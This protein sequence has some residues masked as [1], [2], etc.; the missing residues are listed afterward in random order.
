MLRQIQL[1]CIC[2]F[3]QQKPMFHVCAMTG[4]KDI[5]KNSVVQHI[6]GDLDL[7]PCSATDSPG[8][9]GGVLHYI[10]ASLSC[11]YK[12]NTLLS[13]FLSYI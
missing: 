13:I 5:F 12:K 1:L 7:F 2:V 3:K 8:D 9:L 11:L 4:K 10:C 6:S